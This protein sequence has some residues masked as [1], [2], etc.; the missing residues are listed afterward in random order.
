MK[1]LIDF[2]THYRSLE[3]GINKREIKTL[4]SVAETLTF[5]T[6]EGI[7]GSVASDLIFLETAGYIS[8]NEML[9]IWCSRN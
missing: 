1:T 3:R 5:E 2:I 6:S 9:S 4:V 7:I 8:T